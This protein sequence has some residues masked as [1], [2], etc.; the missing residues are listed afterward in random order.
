MSA[1]TLEPGNDVLHVVRIGAF[2]DNYIWLLRDPVSGATAL[3]D[4]G[5]AEA[6]AAALDARGWTPTHV[7]VTHHHNDHIGGLA[8]L[9]ARF[10]AARVF[11]ARADAR[12]IAPVD[13]F[14]DDGDCVDF[15]AL[16]G[17]VLAAPGHTSGH[18][19]YWFERAAALFC[20]DALFSQGCGR[21]FEGTPAQMWASLLKLR[22][23]PPET[24]V[25]CAH[26]YTAGNARFAAAIEPA[27]AAVAARNAET[28]RRRA[29]GLPTV[30]SL[31]A[32]EC[33]LNPFLRA[34]DPALQAALGMSGADPV[35][36]FADVRARK[37]VFRG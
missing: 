8:A 16:T 3:V 37:D 10:P 7:F 1:Q 27:N 36:V 6:A 30:P 11:A 33:V 19:V 24:A 29:A 5:D 20:G 21:L 13:V 17:R 18:I 22:A 28:A 9:K 23:L 35:A 26:E 32:D 34:D 4:P 25:Y 15:G 14:L 12:R 31:L 2:D